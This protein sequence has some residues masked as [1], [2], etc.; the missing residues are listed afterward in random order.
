M[1]ESIFLRL[2]PFED[3]S[4]ALIEGIDAIGEGR[5]A[6]SIVHAV[7]PESFEQVPGS[8]FAYW[9]SERIRRLFTELPPFEG[10]GRTVRQGLATSD[11]FRFVRLWWEI[12]PEKTVTGNSETTLE[13]FRQQTYVGKHWVPFAKGGAYA[14][15][16]ADL[17]LVVNWEGEG[18]EIKSE[19]DRKYSHIKGYQTFWVVKNPDFYFRSGMTWPLRARRFAPQS[20]PSGAICS[21]RGYGVFCETSQLPNLVGIGNSFPFDYLYKIM[22][23]RFEFPEFIV[24]IL[25][26][27]PIPNDFS[28]RS[29]NLAFIAYKAF[30]EK[31]N[32]D[33]A[34]ET[35][36]IFHL[37]ALLQTTGNSLIDRIADWQSRLTEAQQKLADYQSEIDDI[38]FQLYGIEGDDRRAIEESLG[39]VHSSAEDE[40]AES[41]TDEEDAEPEA[42]V[43]AG[44][45]VADLISYTFG[46]VFGRW[47]VRFATGELTPPELPDPFA[48]LPVC[49]PGMLKGADGLPLN[50]APSGYPL[51][52]DWDGILVDD[53]DHKDDIIRRVRDVMELIFKD[54][55]EAIER[56]A[57]E[58]IGVKQLR[59]YFSKSGAGGFWSDHVKRYSKSRRKAP[60]YC[61]LQSSKKSY[62]VWLYYP[63]LDKDML[64]KALINYVEP[65]IRLEENNLEQSRAKRAAAGTAGREAKQLEREIDQQGNLLSEL[66]DFRD[67]LRRAAELRLDPDLNDGV[68][69]NIAPL[70]ELVPWNEPKKYWEALLEGK[71]EWSSVGKQLREKGLIKA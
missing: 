40:E 64:F 62:G 20:L 26:Q 33:T 17:H 16:Y 5:A 14:P 13:Q 60:I 70:W 53:A 9:V 63:R 7:N 3:K 11:D 65:K 56:E 71:Y 8:P 44:G 32:Q 22:L 24:G 47:D 12:S 49:S 46:S 15:F 1:N 6:G 23:G 50:E 39:S 30:T 35:S 51:E 19:V 10:E 31:R 67:K 48:P 61:L 42:T 58:I 34:N 38:A 57:A 28:S 55:A 4:E 25:Q 37:A 66:R 36:H 69:L 21:A 41:D 2:L 43:D 54:R 45:L 29:N 27:L 68:I 18:T 52:I 59:D